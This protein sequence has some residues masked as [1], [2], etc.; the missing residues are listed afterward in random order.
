[1][2]ICGYIYLC[3]IYIIINFSGKSIPHGLAENNYLYC[4][5]YIF[6]AFD[7]SMLTKIVMCHI[8]ILEPKCIGQEKKKK[9]VQVS[10]G[11]VYFF[12]SSLY[13]NH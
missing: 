5:E 7:E 4:P 13:L 10:R 3:N 9:Q 12:L 11:F 8:L 2:C 6:L 1:M